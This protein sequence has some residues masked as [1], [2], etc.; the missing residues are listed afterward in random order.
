MPIGEKI[1]TRKRLAV[2]AAAL[3]LAGAAGYLGLTSTGVVSSS[4]AGQRARA[5]DA[6]VA[7]TSSAPG[8]GTVVGGSAGAEPVGGGLIACPMIPAVADPAGGYGGDGVAT[9]VFTRTTADGVTIRAY[10]LPSTGSCG[11]GPIP[12]ATASSPSPGSSGSAANEPDVVSG[13]AVSVELSD[14][15]AVGEGTLSAAPSLSATT[16]NADTEPFSA[17]SGAFGVTEGAPVWW[18]AV[19]VGPAVVSAKMTFAGGS[20]DQMAPV[21]GVAV[22]AY[23]IDPAVASSGEGPYQVRGTLQLLDASGAVISTVTFP[24]APPTLVPSPIPVLVSPPVTVPGSTSS[25]GPILTSPPVAKV[26]G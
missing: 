21:D 26:H 4:T 3:V 20:V 6:R 8:S 18:T 7:A 5:D 12:Q 16:M 13:G 2:M 15:S 23:Q 9:H 10:R 11:S 19:S 1:R 14:E 22:L 24:E 25:P 17:V